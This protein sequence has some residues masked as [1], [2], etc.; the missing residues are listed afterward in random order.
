MDL[1]EIAKKYG[2]DQE[3][4]S[5][6]NELQADSLDEMRFALEAKLADMRPGDSA[7][8]YTYNLPYSVVQR[9]RDAIAAE[10]GVY[11]L[12]YSVYEACRYAE[13]QGRRQDERNVRRLLA[14]DAAKPVAEQQ[15]FAFEKPISPTKKIWLVP[16]AAW[17]RH[18]DR[19]KG[20]V[21]GRPRRIRP[22]SEDVNQE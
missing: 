8:G 10:S 11:D 15:F 22:E 3:I 12:C 18:I 2:W 13:S 20:S 9:L 1:D 16:K 21:R 5:F 17:H 19:L 14:E 6:L 7:V 4:R